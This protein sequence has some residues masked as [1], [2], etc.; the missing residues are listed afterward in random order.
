MHSAN[1]P[2]GGL[3]VLGVVFLFIPAMVPTH[4]FAQENYTVGNGT[5]AH[6]CA[7]AYC[8]FAWEGTDVYAEETYFAYTYGCMSDTSGQM[9]DPIQFLEYDPPPEYGGVLTVYHFLE[10][11]QDPYDELG[12]LYI[13]TH[14]VVLQF[15]IETYEYSSMGL[16]WRDSYYDDYV[17]TDGAGPDDGEFTPYELRKGAVENQAYTISVCSPFIRDR[18]SLKQALVYLGICNSYNFTYAFTHCGARVAIG[19]RVNIFV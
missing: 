15:V 5:N 13:A 4:V 6:H 2:I 18:G 12:V 9:Y 17:D 19:E 11:I 14:G 8:P 1:M 10:M 3:S 7:V 16:A